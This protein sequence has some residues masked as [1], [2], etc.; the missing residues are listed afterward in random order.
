MSFVNIKGSVKRVMIH[1]VVA[2]CWLGPCPVDYE[3]DHIDRNSKNNDYRNLRYVTHSEQMKNR[4]MSNRIINIATANCLNY[5]MTQVAKPV[6]L[7]DRKSNE[8]MRFPSII[9]CSEYLAQ[10]YLKPAEHF[11]NKLKKRRSRIFDYDVKYLRNAQT[12]RV[13]STEQ[14][15][16]G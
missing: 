1:K 11:R 12:G 14:G 4:A 9:R 2:E 15:T 5:T 7:I 8:S 3:V 13:G 10:K 16:V 6:I